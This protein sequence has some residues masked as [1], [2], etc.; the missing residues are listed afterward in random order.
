MSF[1]V[2][3]CVAAMGLLHLAVHA[4][5]REHAIASSIVAAVALPL[6]LVRPEV[7]VL[8]FLVAVGSRR[9]RNPAVPD[10]VPAEW[11]DR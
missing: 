7:A 3:V 8:L 5:A 9:L 4:E 11:A 2:L 10:R 6:A 1:T